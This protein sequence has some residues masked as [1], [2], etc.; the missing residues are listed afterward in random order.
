MLS[1]DLI[2][3]PTAFVPIKGQL[4]AIPRLRPQG[5]RPHRALPAGRHRHGSTR[6]ANGRAPGSLFANLEDGGWA[7]GQ[8]IGP[9]TNGLSTATLEQ[10]MAA[11][12][13]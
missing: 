4:P 12:A 11:C 9:K 1:Q 6:Q 3:T 8:D 2:L 10:H 7:C 5:A 13:C